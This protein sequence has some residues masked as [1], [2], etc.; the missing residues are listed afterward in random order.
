MDIHPWD[1]HPDGNRFLMVKP[2]EDADEASAT[3]LP[4]EINIFL[5]WFE[6]LKNRVSVE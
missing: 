5:N 6:E 1:I 3:A 2:V 4:R